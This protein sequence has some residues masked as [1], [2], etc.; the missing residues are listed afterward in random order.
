MSSLSSPDSI[1]A[2]GDAQRAATAA[3]H[4]AAKR[5]RERLSQWHLLFLLVVVLG[6][7]VVY[8]LIRLVLLS[9]T[10]QHGLTFHANICDITLCHYRHSPVFFAM[11]SEST[12][13]AFLVVQIR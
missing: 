13:T 11:L 12:T 6:P 2:P 7:L 8:P 1:A 10:G 9:L 3:S 5:R 4:A